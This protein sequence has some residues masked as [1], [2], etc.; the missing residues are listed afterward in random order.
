[1]TSSGFAPAKAVAP[2]RH[3]RLPAIVYFEG[4]M[5]A[6]TALAQ[7]QRFLRLPLS[8]LAVQREAGSVLVTSSERMLREHWAA[9][10]GRTRLRIIALSDERFKD[11][12]LDG[13]V[14]AY[15][16]VQTP[17]VLV[18]RMVDGALAHID[19]LAAR[20]EFNHR[21]G[22]ASREIDELNRIG[23][24][25]SA[26]HD[27]GKLLEMILTKSRQITSAD[28]GSLYLVEEVEAPAARNSNLES[29]AGA[30]KHLRF[31]VA[32]NDS[33]PVDF[34][35]S[36]VAIGPESIAGYVAMTGQI[37]NIDDA[38]HLEP[39]VP[40]SI[41][42]KF[43][44]D[45]GY[46]TKSILA[47]PMR[48]Q[49]DEIVGV[50]QLI[51]AK[52]EPKAK[53]NALSNVIVQVIPFSQRHRELV[54]SLASQAAVALENSRLYGS[55]QKLFEGF[56]KASV[57]AIEARDPTTFGHSFRVA[58]LTVALAE[59]VDRIS[60][61]P[62]AP[63]RFS[64][65]QMREIRYAS[66]LHDF[67]KVGVREDVLVKARKLY[68]TQLELLEQRFDF[69]KRTLQ[70]E[71]IQRRLD[72]VLRHGRKRYRDQ[73][74]EFDAELASRIAEVEEWWKVILESNQPSV[75]PE[76]SFDRLRE[77]GAREYTD[78]NGKRRKLLTDE[79]VRLLSIRKGS[80]DHRERRQI[81]SH[82]LHTFQFLSQIPWT[83]EISRIPQI[84]LGHH[85][86]LNGSGYPYN[87]AAPEIPVQTRIMTISDI[88]D[89]LAAADR[90]YKKAVSTERALQILDYSVQDGELDAELFRLFLEAKVF[91]RWKIEPYPY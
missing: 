73:E 45:S 67:G 47:I 7:T 36:T 41:N 31:A 66:L 39:S 71:S 5:P 72:F 32:Q 55:I 37:V 57:T 35:E 53:L 38:Y 50:L 77:I 11:P 54:A 74:P 87:L 30:Q 64:R 90:P 15:L 19:L 17:A 20:Q 4:D 1:M 24:A 84:A 10:R 75:L 8:E 26:E 22:E 83:K 85:E 18:E 68:P 59:V 6:R 70:N 88:F 49:K 27:T 58:N 76:G 61:G 21:L 80:L 46:R 42:R 9:V 28:A 25:L 43:D 62:Y 82:V 3:A 78:V 60:S 89:A 40:Y 69:L 14:Y 2:A 79:E 65:D 23:A 81:E 56:V 63:V 48:N 44:E 16:P 13:T 86:K 52:R 29:G 12:R 34:G 91:E 51:N 33:V